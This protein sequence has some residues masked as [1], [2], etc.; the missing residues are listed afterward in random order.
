MS[1]NRGMDKDDVLHIHDGILLSHKKWNNATCSNM[2]DLEILIPSEVRQWKTNIYN[3]TYMWNLRKG[4]KWTYLPNRN[5][6]TD[7]EDKLM[8]QKGTGGGGGLGDWDWH[9]HIAVCGMTSQWEPAVLHRELYWIFCDSVYGKRIWKIV[10]VCICTNK[11]KTKKIVL[12]YEKSSKCLE[13][14][15]FLIFSD[16]S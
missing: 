16:F 2:D 13:L 14:K 9:M 1:I 4:Y 3:I 5:I 7:F 12:L 15:I 6:R 10:D 8:V 11:Q